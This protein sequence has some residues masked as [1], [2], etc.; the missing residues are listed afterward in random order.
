MSK[1]AFFATSN[2]F[3]HHAISSLARG[4]R[5]VCRNAHRATAGDE[6]CGLRSPRRSSRRN[7]SAAAKPMTA[8]VPQSNSDAPSVAGGLHN[9]TSCQ[10]ADQNAHSHDGVVKNP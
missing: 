4:A 6:G 2:H 8:S 7:P 3:L 9:C 5:G 10:I 1:A